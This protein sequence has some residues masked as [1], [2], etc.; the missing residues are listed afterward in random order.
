LARHITAVVVLLSVSVLSV[1]ALL[2]NLVQQSSVP[3]AAEQIPNFLARYNELHKELP[4]KGEVGYMNDA[5]PDATIRQEEY[6][7]T[8]YALAPAVV[9]D[10]LDQA[11]VVANFHQA[12]DKVLLNAR[13]LTVKHDFGNGVLLLQKAPQ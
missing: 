5:T 12:P 8:Q 7:L 10:S 13:R 3:G 6:Y 9:V 2:L 4:A 1:A 11:L